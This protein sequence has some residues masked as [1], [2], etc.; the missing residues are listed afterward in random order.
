M[1]SA[2]LFTAIPYRGLT[3]RW[4]TYGVKGFVHRTNELLPVL[5]AE[6]D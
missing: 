1:D 6:S 2:L 4:V 3:T 5:L